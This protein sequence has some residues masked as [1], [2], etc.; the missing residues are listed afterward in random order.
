MKRRLFVKSASL[1]TLSLTSAKLLS[2]CGS[3]PSENQGSASQT[4]T[5]NTTA[6]Q[7][8]PEDDTL[9]IDTINFGIIS[10]ESQAHQKPIWEPFIQAMS[11][12]IGMTIKAFYATQY[13]GVIEAMRFEQ[14]QLAWYG[15]KSYIEAA[16][17]AHAEAFALTVGTEGEKGYYSH[18]ITNRN[19]PFLSKAKEMGGDKYILENASDLTFAFNDPNS[20]SGDLVP[21]Y[22]IFANNNVEPKQAFQR[23]V[24]AGSHEATALAVANNQVDVATNNNESLERLEETLPA[25]RDKIETI[26]TSPIIPSDPIAYRKDL[27]ESL[28]EKIRNFFYNYSEKSV[29]KPLGWSGFEEA[30]DSRWD[31]VRELDIGRQIMEVKSNPDLKP[32]EKEARL[33]ELNKQLEKLST[34]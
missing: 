26:W 14:V 24:F 2:S 17:P 9:D 18:L 23:L 34:T 22:Y 28:K 3:N 5:T 25:A 16:K 30:D 1:F 31:T 19:Q 29:L 12:E 13:A 10:T 20:T 4:E 15:G 6:S 7:T 21:S 8:T 27:P 33:Q 32:E 11:E